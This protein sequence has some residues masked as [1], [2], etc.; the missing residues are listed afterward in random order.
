MTTLSHTRQAA[1][2]VSQ[3]HPYARLYRAVI[4]RAVQDLAQEQHRDEAREW[5]FSSHSDYAFAVSG[6]S[7]QSIRISGHSKGSRFY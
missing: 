7:P 2:L 4:I 3:Q 1:P 5:L 6:I